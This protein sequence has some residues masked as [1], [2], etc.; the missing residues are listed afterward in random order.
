MSAFRFRV[1]TN[2]DFTG[3][4]DAHGRSLSSVAK[5]ISRP[6]L[7]ESPDQARHLKNRG[8]YKSACCCY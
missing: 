5:C 6:I 8:L 3:K 7:W 1:A 2:F 4:F